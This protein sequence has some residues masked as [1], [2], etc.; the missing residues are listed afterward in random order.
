VLEVRSRW[1][2][3]KYGRFSGLNQ[4]C[5]GASCVS[6]P[7]S[8][9][10]VPDR[11]RDERR[12]GGGDEPRNGDGGSGNPGTARTPIQPATLAFCSAELVPLD[13]PISPVVV[14]SRPARV[15]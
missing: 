4:E 2:A 12:R 9:I 14:M 10:Q 5:A 8:S 1:H 11:D 7:N 6:D 3:P 15:G 13:L